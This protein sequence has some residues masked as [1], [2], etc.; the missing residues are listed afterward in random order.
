MIARRAAIG[1]LAAPF[2]A[3]ALL[4]AEGASDDP[5][6]DPG[7]EIARA[8][9]A[10]QGVVTIYDPAYVALDFPGGDVAPERGVCTDVLIRALRVAHGLDLQLAVNADMRAN[11]AAYP[12]NWGLSRP[13]RNIDHR[14][15]PNLRRLFERTGAEIPVS[16]DPAAYKP[17]DVV[18]CLIPGDLAHLMVVGSGKSAGGTPLIVHNIGRGSLIEDRLFEFRMTGLYRI[19]PEVLRKLQ[20]LG[21]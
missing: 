12:K 4:R 16:E 6:R 15:V 5:A 20:R 11:F 9:E 3:P 10:Q 13:D 17:G 2:L 21:A 7:P 18:T 1:L 8:A 19:T 14:R